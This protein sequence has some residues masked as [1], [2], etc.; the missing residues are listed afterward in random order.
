VLSERNKVH[1]NALYEAQFRVILEI[2]A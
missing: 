2:E 1:Q